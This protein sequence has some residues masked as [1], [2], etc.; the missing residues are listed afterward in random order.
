MSWE[1]ALR[2]GK[3]SPCTE[4]DVYILRQVMYHSI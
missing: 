4:L 1:W 2:E 3:G